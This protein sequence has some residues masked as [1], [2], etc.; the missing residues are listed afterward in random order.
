MPF[1]ILRCESTLEICEEKKHLDTPCDYQSHSFFLC[2]VD[3]NTALSH[4]WAK[5]MVELEIA[6]RK[7]VMF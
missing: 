1:C 5:E 4:A 6:R 2:L 7:D 3:H